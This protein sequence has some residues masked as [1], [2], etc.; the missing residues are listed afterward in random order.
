MR[1][2][3]IHAIE[4]CEFNRVIDTSPRDL[5]QAGLFQDIAV[6]LRSGRHEEVSAGLFAK[7]LHGHA[8]PRKFKEKEES[9][10]ARRLSQRALTGLQ[11]I[12]CRSASQL[13]GGLSESDSRMTSP[14]DSYKLDESSLTASPTPA[15]PPPTARAAS[16]GWGMVRGRVLGT[17]VSAPPRARTTPEADEGGAAEEAAV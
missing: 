14:R 6:E 17:G 16:H 1:V 2:L 11:S 15:R 5:V 8:F 10:P 13:D 4:D 9:P 3:L 7:A 12:R